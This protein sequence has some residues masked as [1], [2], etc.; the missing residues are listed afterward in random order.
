M[1]RNL[2][3]F[4]PRGGHARPAIVDGV[5]YPSRFHAMRANPEA[6]T[7]DTRAAEA[8]AFARWLDDLERTAPEATC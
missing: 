1:R 5:E 2:L 3:N 6:F 7:A 8:E 4:A